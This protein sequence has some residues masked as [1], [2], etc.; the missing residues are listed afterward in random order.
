MK[1]PDTITA[2]PINE[3]ALSGSLSMIV[4]HISDAKGVIYARFEIFAVLPN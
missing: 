2:S 1:I 4:V 3:K